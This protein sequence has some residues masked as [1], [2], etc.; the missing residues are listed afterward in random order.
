MFEEGSFSGEGAEL[1]SGHGEERLNV[2]L[3][4]EL[5]GDDPKVNRWV[6]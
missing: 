4:D 6:A 5:D 3:L 2:A 1:L